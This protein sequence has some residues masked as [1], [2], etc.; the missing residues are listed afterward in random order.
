LQQNLRGA[1]ALM[2]AELRMLD[3][4]EGDIKAMASDSIRIRAMRQLAVI[5]VAPVLG[6]AQP[7]TGPTMTVRGSARGT[8]CSSARAPSARPPTR[9]W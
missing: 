4:S 1:A 5:C 2:A 6:G 3:A 7:L 8:R 9:S